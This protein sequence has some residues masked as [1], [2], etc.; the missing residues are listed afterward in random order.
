MNNADKPAFPT[1]GD[2]THNPQ[3][4]TIEG[5]TKREYFAAMADV[6][7]NAVIETMR[8]DGITRPTVKQA[9]E[10]RAAMKV[11]EADALLAELDKN[12]VKDGM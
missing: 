9:A 10:Y 5:L 8:L 2:I 4:D 1:M 7:W 11:C 6:P 12:Y 3:F